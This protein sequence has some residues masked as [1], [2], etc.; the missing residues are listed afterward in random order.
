MYLGAGKDG[1]PGR[2]TMIGIVNVESLGGYA[3]PGVV[4]RDHFRKAPENAGGPRYGLGSLRTL[5]EATIEPGL[6]FPT[7][8]HRDFEIVSYVCAGELT[9]RD[10]LGHVGRLGAGD[11]QVMTAGAGISHSEMNEGASV[12]RI[13]QL[14]IEPARL[15]LAPRYV[16]LHRSAAA[17]RG[18]LR[19]IASGRETMQGAAAIDQDAALSVVELEAG[20]RIDYPM[21]ADRRL[22]VLAAR[23]ALTLNGVP[24]PERD[25]AL[26]EDE[27]I[28]AIVAAAGPAG[29]AGARAEA[30]IIDLPR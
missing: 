24:L 29:A 30:L 1:S 25:G 12:T 5:A 7:H 23:G 22:Y 21:E 28:L 20:Q 26:V 18:D 3:L 13:Y 9:H 17:K 14:W 11:A 16:D 19:V 27:W 10:T 15:G 6:G 8:G 2:E 4:V